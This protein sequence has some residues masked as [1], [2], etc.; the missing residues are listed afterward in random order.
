M[1]RSLIEH[2]NNSYDSLGILVGNYVRGYGDAW[3]EKYLEYEYPKLA[4]RIWDKPTGDDR[5]IDDW[6]LKLELNSEAQSVQI[7]GYPFVSDE[8]EVDWSMRTLV[9]S[10]P[11]VF[12]ERLETA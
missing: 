10:K 4:Y 7:I 3:V 5:L 12:F 9:S 8:N 2:V 1:K 11:I 6:V